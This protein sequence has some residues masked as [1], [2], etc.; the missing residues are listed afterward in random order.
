MIM[1]THLWFIKCWCHAEHNV[2]CC[3]FISWIHLFKTH[4]LLSLL[5]CSF[6]KWGNWVLEELSHLPKV[7]RIV[8]VT[9]VFESVNEK[10]VIGKKKVGGKL[11][12]FSRIL[13]FYWLSFLP[14]SWVSGNCRYS[15]LI[16]KFRRLKNTLFPLFTLLHSDS[17]SKYLQSSNSLPGSFVDT[18]RL[19]SAF[20]R[21][22]T[23]AWLM[24]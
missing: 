3:I 18:L 12:E 10:S 9:E 8:H 20:T 2:H 4:S 6:H 21:A 7:K 19:L 15:S 22:E 14:S 24:H 11:M 23:E 5:C 17:N 16:P 13:K 1:E